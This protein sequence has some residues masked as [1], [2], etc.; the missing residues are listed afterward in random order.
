M[1]SSFFESDT[2]Q[3]I[4]ESRSKLA[5]SDSLSES[6]YEER[7]FKGQGYELIDQNQFSSTISIIW[8]VVNF[9]CSEWFSEKC[10]NFVVQFPFDYVCKTVSR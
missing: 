1:R 9:N 3:P 2:D 8:H 7:D 10:F 5:M 6:S 4:T